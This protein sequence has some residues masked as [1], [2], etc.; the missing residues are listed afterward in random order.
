MTEGLQIL[1][2]R[3]GTLV[4]SYYGAAV[5][6]TILLEIGAQIT[7]SRARLLWSRLERILGRDLARRILDNPLVQNAGAIDWQS[8]MRGRGVR[9]LVN[10][11]GNYIS[12]IEPRDFALAAVQELFEPK[13]G[14]SALLKVRTKVR[15]SPPHPTQT[16]TH[17]PKVPAG[18]VE[19]FETLIQG[20]EGV[21]PH[22]LERVENW[23]RRDQQQLTGIYSTRTRWVGVLLGTAIALWAGLDTIAILFPDAFVSPRQTWDARYWLGCF[24]SGLFISQGAQFWF[25]IATRITNLRSGGTTPK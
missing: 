6:I 16:A 8:R 15:T 19:L 2:T 23:F 24:V 11:S 22:I 9:R 10:R 18:V 25:D 14:G 4:S 12:W 21:Q 17:A 5:L 20:T 7:V 13:A 3:I 1:I